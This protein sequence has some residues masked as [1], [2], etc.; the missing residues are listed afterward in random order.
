MGAAA[1]A[2]IAENQNRPSMSMGDPFQM[3]NQA[4]QLR[5]NMQTWN[6]QQEA[7]RI[8]AASPDMDTAVNTMSKSPNAAWMLPT[9]NQMRTIQQ[10]EAEIA[11]A[12][13]ATGQIGLDTSFTR[14]KNTMLMNPNDPL[15]FV[16][17][18]QAMRENMSPLEL[19]M[20][21][22]YIDSVE[23]SLM[24]GLPQGDDPASQAKA[25]QMFNQR[26]IAFR[27][28]AGMTP[29][30]AYGTV[31]AIAPSFEQLPPGRMGEERMGVVGGLGGGPGGMD[32]TGSGISGNMLGGT[33]VITGPS[34]PW[35]QRIGKPTEAVQSEIQDNSMH[36]PGLLNTMKIMYDSLKDFQA[37]GGATAMMNW[38]QRLQALR[39]VTGGLIPQSLVDAA[40][41]D[42]LAQ[43]QV[44]S[45]EI[46]RFVTD[47]MRQAVAGTGAGRIRNEVEAFLN[48]M[49]ETTDPNAIIKLMNQQMY[50]L[51]VAADQANQW[52]GYMQKVEA[53]DP[54]VAGMGPGD[55]YNW[56]NNNRGKSPDMARE[57]AGFSLM[58]M[59]PS[60]VKGGKAATTTRTIPGGPSFTMGPDGTPTDATQNG[61]KF[62]WNGPKHPTDAQLHNKG[63]WLWVPQE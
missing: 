29:Q 62:R 53:N 17:G 46:K 38:G 2:S 57:T 18:L 51:R 39:R 37:G 8:L 42:N 5:N 33:G 19:K 55:F 23:Q 43:S 6:S 20:N 30:Q 24:E 45:A 32:T 7:G 58:P 25:A 16:K 48:S 56:W 59:D 11:K 44:F 28:G 47:Q 34:E 35:L 13:A 41:N 27:M 21:G 50:S 3:V 31:G 14:L 49:K 12:N 36:A 52:P 63:N 60:T 9:I 40:G 15:G 1:V 54:S 10:T 61:M 26:M 22:K 4:M